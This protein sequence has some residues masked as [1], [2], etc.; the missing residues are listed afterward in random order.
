M[1]P[2]PSPDGRVPAGTADRRR[3]ALA[4]ALL[5][6]LALVHVGLVYGKELTPWK[7]GGFGMFSTLDHEGWRVVRLL[8]EDGSGEEPVRVRLPPRLAADARRARILPD[9]AALRRLAAGV[10]EAHPEARAVHVRVLRT[11]FDR[12]L[13]PHTQPLASLRV[14]AEQL[15]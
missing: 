9:E 3:A 15:R 4:P 5:V 12:D 8:V 10:L 11:R 1:A 13:R 7:G 14:A 2:R 6:V